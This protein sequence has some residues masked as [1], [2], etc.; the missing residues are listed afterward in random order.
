METL[1]SAKG[2]VA[3]R[4][5]EI[6]REEMGRDARRPSSGRAY[7]WVKQRLLVLLNPGS[8]CRARNELTA[9]RRV[10]HRGCDP[11][12]MAQLVE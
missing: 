6:L 8:I 3:A 2:D 5:Q 9:R 11:V 7:Q 4:S 10:R 1:T 12:H